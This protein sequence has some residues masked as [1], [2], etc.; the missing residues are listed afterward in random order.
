MDESDEFYGL[1][2]CFQTRTNRSNE[3]NELNK[4]YYDSIFYYDQAGLKIDSSKLIQ[5]LCLC[6]F[7]HIFA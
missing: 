1:D 3:F 6:G 4:Y 7:N 5:S 2:K